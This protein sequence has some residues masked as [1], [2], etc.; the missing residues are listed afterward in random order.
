MGV[1]AVH[2]HADLDVSHEEVS[3]IMH[4]L[5]ACRIPYVEFD[6]VFFTI[7]SYLNDFAAVR[8]YFRRSTTHKRCTSHERLYYARFANVSIAH[9]YY[10]GALHLFMSVSARSRGRLFEAKSVRLG[11][12][13]STTAATPF[14]FFTQFSCLDHLFIPSFFNK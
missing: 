12:F 14:T 7:L 5:L 3:Q 4:V 9:K 10:F 11:S 8:H 1:Y 6:L 2:Q 13:L